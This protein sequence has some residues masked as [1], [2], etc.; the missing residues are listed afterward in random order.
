MEYLLSI[1]LCNASRDACQCGPAMHLRGLGFHE[2]GVVK[3]FDTFHVRMEE[4]PDPRML[5]VPGV[6]QIAVFSSYCSPRD[7]HGQFHAPSIGV[8]L[9][10]SHPHLPD[11][12]ELP[13]NIQNELN[14]RC[15]FSGPC[16]VCGRHWHHAATKGESVTTEHF[17]IFID[18]SFVLKFKEKVLECF[19]EVRVDA[20]RKAHQRL[21]TMSV[22]HVVVVD[23]SLD[24]TC[25]ECRVQIHN[26]AEVWTCF[27]CTK[28]L[29][30][31]CKTTCGQYSSHRRRCFRTFCANCYAR[32]VD[33]GCAVAMLQSGPF[34]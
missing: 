29:C 23:P 1:L 16:V 19:P 14:K 18:M 3:H 24:V 20:L 33:D 28:Q 7:H 27:A 15:A 2:H 8:R 9:Y 25:T 32:H 34:S 10:F 22:A 17:M 12:P 13:S 4:E 30:H 6:W 31:A 11:C 26:L 21:T 5:S